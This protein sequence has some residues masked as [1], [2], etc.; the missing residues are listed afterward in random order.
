M[1]LYASGS[2]FDD[3]V[4]QLERQGVVFCSQE[5]SFSNTVMGPSEDTADPVAC[6]Y[7]DTDKS[8]E[9]LMEDQASNL[10]AAANSSL[11]SNSTAIITTPSASVLPGA[12]SCNCTYTSMA[13]CHSTTG[14]T[15]EVP[16]SNHGML[17][18]PLARCCNATTGRIQ[19]GDSS[20]GITC[21]PSNAEA[22]AIS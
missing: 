8:S 16:S 13:C 7:S 2:R 12:C 6:G 19:K 1:T 5:A 3:S 17:K 14:I 21:N 20:N 9:I 15:Y 18:L 11:T 4:I 10:T 22:G